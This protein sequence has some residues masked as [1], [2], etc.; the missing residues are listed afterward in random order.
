MA[1]SN[2]WIL[3]TGL[4]INGCAQTSLVPIAANTYEITVSAA[5]ACGATGAVELASHDA[6]IATLR[7]GF[8]SYII[9]RGDAQ[10]GALASSHDQEFVIRM[11]RST[12]PDGQNS[13]SA[14]TA[15]GPNWA[16]L[17]SKG[18]PKTCT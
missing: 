1:F 3:L 5:P 17:V 7:N 18:F 14:R 10:S 4:L 9:L 16:A 11:F 15:L 12:D 8:D 6:A 2:R 13:I